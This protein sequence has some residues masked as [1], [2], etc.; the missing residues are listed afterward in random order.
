MEQPP[1]QFLDAGYFGAS[2]GAAAALNPAATFGTSI[3]AV[4]SRGG[5]PNL[6]MS[7]LPQVQSASVQSK[8][9]GMI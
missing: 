5:R 7:A 4:V 1:S 9:V 2:T 6:A 8:P 3:G